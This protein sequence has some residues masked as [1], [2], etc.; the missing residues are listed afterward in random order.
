MFTS[1]FESI[2]YVGHLVPVAF[3]RVFMGYY[4]F[5]RAVENTTNGFL[6]KPHLAAS[7]NEW[8]PLSSAPDW[9][10]SFLQTF[11]VSNWDLFAYFINGFQFLIAF[12][13]VVGFAVR[14]VSVLGL[15]MSLNFLYISEP[16]AGDLYRFLL[17]L[18]IVMCWIGAGR[19]LGVDYFFY[20]RNRGI[21]W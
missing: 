6:D 18:F 7:I 2:K 3:M 1:F 13:F 15:I 4:F 9:Y 21:W 11:V 8:V 5:Q 20:K 19:S 17:A 14:P 10:K 16:A 12:S